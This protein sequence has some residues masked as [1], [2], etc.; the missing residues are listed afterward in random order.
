MK[1]PGR[2]YG[3][4]VW[5]HVPDEAW[6]IMLSIPKVA[7]EVFPYSARSVSA[8]FTRVA[9]FLE[10]EDMHFNPRHDG[11]GRL[12]EMGWD[13][14]ITCVCIRALRLELNTTLYVPEG[15]WESL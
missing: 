1:N 8:S 2:K 14:Q 5:C 4:D 11:V 3:N 10:I 7:D 12:L 13:I 6:R 9:A 15:E